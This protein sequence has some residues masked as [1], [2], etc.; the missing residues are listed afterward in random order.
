MSQ[1]SPYL[2]ITFTLTSVSHLYRF[3]LFPIIMM[4][5]GL[6]THSHL[7]RMKCGSMPR[8]FKPIL[9]QCTGVCSLLDLCAG[10]LLHEA[11][12]PVFTVTIQCF[13]SVSAYLKISVISVALCFS[14][15]VCLLPKSFELHVPCNGT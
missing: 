14:I 15:S 9:N 13:V 2:S 10:S 3:F 1:L 4:T 11:N 12:S 6:H 7:P 5:F 8:H